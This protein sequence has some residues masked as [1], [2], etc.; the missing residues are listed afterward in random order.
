MHFLPKLKIR[1]AQQMFFI[2]LGSFFVIA[3]VIVFILKAKTNVSLLSLGKILSGT[4]DPFVELSLGGEEIKL[5]L[6]DFHRIQIDKGDVTWDMKAG[7]ARYLPENNLAYVNDPDIVI[8]RREQK[9]FKLQARAGKL[10]LENEQMKKAELEGDIH[11]F[12]DDFST[13]TDYAVLEVAKEQ[14]NSPNTV[15]FEGKGFKISGKGMR[16]NLNN[17]KIELQS[18]VRSEFVL[19]ELKKQK[20]K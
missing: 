19:S 18:R 20:I 7:E 17:K 13:K 10:Y 11:F 2:V 6:K 5:H 16:V 1:T 15:L 14:L 12:S 9:P 3:V 8:Y 4:E